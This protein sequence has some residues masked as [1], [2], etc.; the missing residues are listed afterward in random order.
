[1]KRLPFLSV[2]A[3][4]FSINQAF[5]IPPIGSGKL[6]ASRAGSMSNVVNQSAR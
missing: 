4:V 2:F 1:M 3:L 6:P 5:A